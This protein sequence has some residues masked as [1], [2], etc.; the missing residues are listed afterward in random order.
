MNFRTMLFWSCSLAL[1]L[2][3]YA[4]SAEPPRTPE[5]LL[6]EAEELVDWSR[7]EEGLERS[8]EAQ[9]L[10]LEEA[11]IDSLLL[12]RGYFLAALAAVHIDLDTMDVYA[13]KF[14]ALPLRH[15]KKFAADSAYLGG[16]LQVQAANY[17]EAYQLMELSRSRYWI[18]DST[19]RVIQAK[20]LMN[21]ANIFQIVNQGDSAATNGNLALDLLEGSLP[22][23]HP[24]IGKAHNLRGLGY[25]KSNQ[26]WKS[27]ADL[28]RALS[29][30]ESQL[31]PN[32]HEIGYVLNN[33]G[34]L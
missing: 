1:G 10:L 25:M 15:N 33:L 20:C 26:R 24:L 9:I 28:R 32:H 16:I 5:E 27:E 4:C 7:Y 23:N 12:L 18:H 8:K 31:P 19:D 14:F 11:P 21:K 13:D 3:L 29:I 17:F 6:A 22:E 34:M 30:F 2:M